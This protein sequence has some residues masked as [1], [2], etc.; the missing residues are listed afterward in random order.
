VGPGLRKIFCVGMNKTG[1]KSLQA[2]LRELGFR[3]GDLVKGELLIDDWS[4]RDFRRIIEHCRTADAFKDIP[5]SCDFTYQAVDGAFPGSKFILS[6]RNSPD[7]WFDSLV[8]FHTALLGKDRVPTAGDLKDYHYRQVGW[9]WRAQ[10]LAYGIDESTL[11]D[12]PTYIRRYLAH[13]ERVIEYFRHRP[14]DLLVLNVGEANAIQRL[15]EFLE[16][17]FA[18]RQMPHLNKAG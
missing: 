1:T 14:A 13:N 9:M 15:C 17:P 5:F 6:V 10:V 12:R 11:Y 3:V 8:R 2:A 4:R 16:M 18:G 7:D